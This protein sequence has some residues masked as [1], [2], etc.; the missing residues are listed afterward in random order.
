EI[1][2][3]LETIKKLSDDEF[4]LRLSWGS[5]WKGMT[6]DYFDQNWLATFRRKYQLGKRDF[7][8]FPKTRRIVFE[9][10]EPKYL[11]GWVKIKLNDVLEIENNKY[12]KSL[13]SSEQTDP[14]ELL[15]Q[16]FKVTETKKKK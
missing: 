13:K 10:E 1:E 7:P 8:I 4:I 6:G 15:K 16:N 12:E 14:L 11:T 5:G 9:G 2:K 3:L